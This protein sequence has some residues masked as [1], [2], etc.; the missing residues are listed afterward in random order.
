MYVVELPV[1]PGGA[2]VVKVEIREVDEG[3]QQVARPGQV[4]ARASRSLGEMLGSVR[5]VAETFVENFRGLA[6]APD[7]LTLSFGVSLTAEADALITSTSATANF[8]V[9][10]VWRRTPA[11]EAAQA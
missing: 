3:I 11:G 1:G 2:D 5:P 6:Q 8:S 9:S 7:E 10:L 4:V